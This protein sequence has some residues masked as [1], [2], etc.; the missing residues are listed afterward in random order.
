MVKVKEDMTGWIMSEHGVHDSRLTVIEQ[1]EDYIKP[2]GEHC[3]QWLCECSCNLHAKLIVR[4]TNLKNGH[5]K[6]CGCLARELFS[7]IHKKQN[8]YDL[9]G[10]YGIGYCSNTGSEFY[11]DLEDYDKIKNYCWHEDVDWS[12]HH[13]VRTKMKTIDGWKNIRMHVF[14]GYKL[15]DHIDRN[16]LNNRKNN[17]KQATAIENAR[18][19]S[20][21][22]NNTS[23]FIGVSYDK[24]KSKWYAQIVVD[25]KNKYLGSFKN[26]N[27]AIKARLEAEA[28]YFGEFAP[29]R[30]LF[31]EHGIT[32]QN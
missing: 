32:I 4:G 10:E 2:N 12:G 14:L 3:A 7:Q 23:G 17:L 21:Q 26:I 9:S 5:T 22:S 8:E 11:F 6:S 25:R 24:N 1:V 15:C 19:R 20:K 16:S 27:D 31:E 30:H 29:Q 18:N 28:K 13:T